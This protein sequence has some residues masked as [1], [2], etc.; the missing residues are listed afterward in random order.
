MT[1]GWLLLESWELTRWCE[2]C[3]VQNVSENVSPQRDRT[4][5]SADAWCDGHAALWNA[6]HDSPRIHCRYAAARSACELLCAR[7][8][9]SSIISVAYV[10]SAAHSFCTRHE[11]CLLSSQWLLCYSDYVQVGKLYHFG[12][13]R[14][15]NFVTSAVTSLMTVSVCWSSRWSIRDSSTATL[16]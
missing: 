11:F 15:A 12:S 7:Y 10:S 13:Q 9:K 4:A 5:R 14:Y 16:S 3:D 8:E 1:C 6:R 2:G